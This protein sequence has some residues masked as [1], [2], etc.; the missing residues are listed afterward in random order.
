MK[1]L[2]FL[3][4][5]LLTFPNLAASQQASAPAPSSST[6]AATLL[7]QS[8]AA[9][10]GR[11]A[12]SDVTL[13][14]T[15]RRIAGS[16]DE[17]GTVVLTA[18]ASGSSKLAL[19]FASGN[20]NEVRANSSNG[21]TGGWSGPDGAAHPI[22]YHNLMTDSGLFPAF[23]LAS[24]LA[25]QNTVTTYVG[26]E[27]RNGASVI[28]LS[29]Y[30]QLPGITGDNAVLPH[31]LSQ[32]EIFLDPTTLLPSSIA[33]N[34]HADN[35]ALLDIPIEIDFSDYRVVNGIR[36]PFHMQKSINHS[37][38]LDLQFQNVTTN[39]GLSASDFTVGA[40]L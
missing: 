19:S 6:Q 10:T 3:T 14:G 28:H 5:L 16:D 12:L 39:S 35:N 1:L 38:S 30:Q 25:S 7:T 8:A 15:A 34:T 13:S 9:L 27:T 22:S 17:S 31:H 36:V 26:Q 11:V 37:L 29:A 2:S 40:G 4:V 20:R 32:I 24:L 33:Y 21:P 23:A 18:T